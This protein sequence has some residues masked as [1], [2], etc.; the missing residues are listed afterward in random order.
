MIKFH[1]T[2]STFAITTFYER[3]SKGRNCDKCDESFTRERTFDNLATDASVYNGIKS[4]CCFYTDDKFT[5][6]HRISNEF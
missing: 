1:F 2:N 4:E 3:S 6:N 5:E